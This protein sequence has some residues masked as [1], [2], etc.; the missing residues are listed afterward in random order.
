MRPLFLLT[1]VPA[2]ALAQPKADPDAPRLVIDSGGHSG[3]ITGV[4][5]AADGT[6]AVTTG[7]DKV[8]RVWDMA[9]G[10]VLRVIRPPAGPGLEGMLNALAVAPDG[11]TIAVGGLPPNVKENGYRIY[12]IDLPTG[13]ILKTLDGHTDSIT[14][15]SFGPL[16]R[17]LA[18]GSLD[19]TVRVYDVSGGKTES[20]LSGHTAGVRAVSFSPGGDA[21][22]SVGEDK[23]CRLWTIPEGKSAGVLK[24]GERPA[25]SVTWSAGG[26]TV[27]VGN[28]DGTISLWEPTGKLRN[29]LQVGGAILSLTYTPDGKELLCTGY[30]PVKASDTPSRAARMI[31]AATGKERVK[32]AQHSDTVLVGGLSPD[33]KLAI[34]GGGDHHEAFAWRPADASLAQPLYGRGG[35][36]FAVGWAADGKA[37]AWGNRNRNFGG[38]IPVERSFLLGEFKVGPPVLGDFS[39]EVL[40]RDDHAI[41]VRD[42]KMYVLDEDKV[43]STFQPDRD[44]VRCATWL[45]EDLVVAGTAFGLFLVDPKTGKSVRR[46]VGHSDEVTSIALSPE[47]LSFVTGSRDQT[48]RFWSVESSK[49]LLSLFVAGQDWIAWTE[50]GVYTCSANGERLMGWQFSE[51][52][53]RL[54]TFLPAAQ[55]RRSLFKPTVLPHL[56]AEGSLDKAF[57]A[58]EL[59]KP[60]DLDGRKLLPPRVEI[61]SPS[62]LGTQRVAGSKFEVTAKAEAVG[63]RPVTALRLLV[64]GRPYGGEAGVRTFEKPAA[65]PVEGKWDVILP[66]GP[67][68]L[69]VVADSAASRGVSAVVDVR[70]PG[71]AGADERPALYVLAAGVNEYVPGLKLKYAAA[72]ADAVAKAFQTFGAKAFRS[73]E[74]KVLKD[75]DATGRGI[76]DGIAWLGSKM[77]PQD[78]GV[79]FFSGHGAKDFQGDFALLPSD[80]DPDSLDRTCIPGTWLK[81]ALGSLPGRVVALLDACYAGLAADRLPGASED[82]LVR[83]LVS[84]D[85]GVAVIS[86]SRAT[87]ESI[88]SGSVKQGFFTKALVEGLSGKADYNKDGVIL[89]AELDR[90]TRV[91]VRD[92][93]RGVQNPTTAKPATLRSFPLAKP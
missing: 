52:Q 68:T 55:F 88:E 46:Y 69:A 25:A 33:G 1:L 17:R 49:P 41:D 70:V 50:E 20:V 81:A 60:A 73:V 44:F 2:I 45:D 31:D 72:D 87:E 16:G 38:K 83:D 34:T 26:R 23:T 10:D 80:L 54:A 77:T 76:A 78:V 84:E 9:T 79:V 6:V 86:S 90:Y 64:N 43:I 42:G 59:E 89:F 24:D 27:A 11:K 29:T 12:L 14:C 75:K 57:A 37:V 63:G 28:L 51:G 62:G 32:F 92:L 40:T 22:A 67:Y 48:I 36:V 35:G 47:G 58:A 21:V 18:S 61:T 56:I 66:P 53:T 3:R 5:F 30:D 7:H 4:A 13:R 39:R 85:Y 74:V 91:R 93:S 8:A 19:K 15:L 71:A 65:G 82:D